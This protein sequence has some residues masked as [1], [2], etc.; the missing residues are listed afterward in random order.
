LVI[1]AIRATIFI[2]VSRVTRVVSVLRVIRA[3]FGLA[4]SRGA[5]RGRS[6]LLGSGCSSFS[7]YTWIIRVTRGL[8]GLLV[9]VGLHLDY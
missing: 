4:Q 7:G 8:L 2:R 6:A 9:V 5:C 1:R 3:L